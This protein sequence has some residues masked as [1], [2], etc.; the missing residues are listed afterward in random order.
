[1]ST[2]TNFKRIALV[3]IAALGMG[4]LSSAP[5]QAVVAATNIT[6]TGA[7]GT[8]SL[9]Q[10]D[11]RTGAT[12]ALTWL[13][14]ATTDSMVI[15]VAAKTKPTAAAA[16]PVGYL[17]V[18]DTTTSV[19]NAVIAGF[20]A[21]SPARANVDNVIIDSL[22]A[23][24]RAQA[25]ATANESF[26]SVKQGSGNNTW[27]AI[28]LRLHMDAATTKAVGTYTYTITATPER[29][30][31][32]L[33]TADAKSIDVSIVIAA[34]DL[35]ASA[36]Y[37][38]AV[39]SSN[40]TSF[41][42]PTPNSDSSVSASAVASGTSKAVLRVSL[43]DATNV[44]GTAAE[45]ITATTTV[46]T[47][48]TTSSSSIGK[49]VVL[50]YNATDV[51]EGYK[52]IFIFADGVS[53]SG[54]ITVS[55]PSVAFA[56]KNLTFYSTTVATMAAVAGTNTI[57]VGVN[58]VSATNTNFGPI[59]G[60][61][62][63]AN[64][65]TVRL[66]ATGSAAVYAYSSDIT[67]IS[68]S[69]TACAFQSSI[70]YAVCPLTGVKAGTAN[71]T[72]RS[73]GTGNTAS[74]IIS[75]PI[76]VTVST[77]SPATLKMAWD[78]ATYAP[79]ER[80]FLKIW[81]V[82]AAGKVLSN[83]TVVGLLASGGLTSNQ[84]FSN[85]TSLPTTTDYALASAVK[86]LSPTTLVDSL[87]PVYIAVLNMPVSGSTVSVTGTGGSAFPTSGRVAV[88]ATATITDNGAA[89]LAAVTAL[90]TTVA[91]LRTLIT[92]L[93]NLVLKIQKKVKA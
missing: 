68:D 77:S 65:N 64:G 89:A 84:T 14:T 52:D 21:T 8:A 87:D 40:A 18:S 46:G 27:N 55:T 4:V 36:I 51:S 48:G 71:I 74:A 39:L 88:T 28:N 90:A 67:V 56:A 47:L 17:S 82:D 6:L 59:W 2:K 22:T 49:S 34:D 32:G 72:L 50:Q 29:V 30:S 63:D 80:A 1:M 35:T 24:S 33:Q 79:G 86:S 10:S 43:R 91:S 25:S 15:T 19:G 42:A 83:Q 37:S 66:N 85:S 16:Y 93:T 76:A 92:T 3:A 73:L 20:G 23:A 58:G 78:K 70:G 41:V 38:T 53:G 45:S 81:A 26:T 5:S 60:L 54:T 12:I 44:K 9:T 57:A 7:N 61:A 13:G 11:S 75:S 31:G 69:G 62:K